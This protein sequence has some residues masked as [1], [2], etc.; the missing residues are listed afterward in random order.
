VREEKVPESSIRI[1]YVQGG[2]TWS[3]GDL[4]GVELVPG[5]VLDPDSVAAACSDRT[6]VFHTAGITSFDP[7]LKRIQWLI[8]VEGT[9]NVLRAPSAR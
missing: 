4:P 2:S 3:I 6:L 1:L 5:D 9:R 7:R 8:N